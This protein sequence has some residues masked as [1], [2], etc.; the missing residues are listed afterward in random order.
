MSCL[1]EMTLLGWRIKGDRD[2]TGDI[3]R[4]FSPNAVNQNPAWRGCHRGIGFRDGVACRTMWPWMNTTAVEAR[5]VWRTADG[6][7][8]HDE[9]AAEVKGADGCREGDDERGTGPAVDAG[10]LWFGVFN[11]GGLD[12]SMGCMTA[13]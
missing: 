10:A 1:P 8:G 11:D 3:I 12:G 9:A 2:G 4:Y 7:I 5:T 6:V 13:F